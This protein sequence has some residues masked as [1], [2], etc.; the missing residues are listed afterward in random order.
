MKTLNFFLILISF[1]LITSF[2]ISIDLTLFS[3]L[4]LFLFLSI[5]NIS[6]K[7][8]ELSSYFLAIFFGIFFDIYTTLF[9]FGFFIIAFVSYVYLVRVVLKKYV[10]IFLFE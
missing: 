10:K 2:L 4:I 3:F 1:F 9:P 8:E 5:F 7:E 6:E